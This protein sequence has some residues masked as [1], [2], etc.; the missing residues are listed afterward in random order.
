M[1]PRN[2]T[3][4]SVFT[5]SFRCLSGFR[6]HHF[7]GESWLLEPKITYSDHGDAD[8]AN[9]LDARVTNA[10]ATTLANARP[11]FMV[12]ARYW[13]ATTTSSSTI[14]PVNL[15][16]RRTVVPYA[17]IFTSIE[18]FSRFLAGG[19]CSGNE[20]S[21]KMNHPQTTFWKRFLHDSSEY[22]HAS[23]FLAAWLP[24]VLLNSGRHILGR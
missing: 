16:R 10:L 3:R 20:F 11:T 6:R 23:L 15:A 7:P 13:S 2:S 12:H 21:E 17:N 18:S 8:V 1:V 5:R 22:R 14:T 24:C 4:I 9:L 19:C